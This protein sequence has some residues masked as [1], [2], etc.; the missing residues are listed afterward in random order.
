MRLAV[1]DV[2]SGATPA[3][4]LLCVTL[5]FAVTYSV[6]IGR[7]DI[8]MCGRLADPLGQHRPACRSALD[9]RAGER[10]RAGAHA[11]HP[12][13]APGRR[14]A[15]GLRRCAAGTFPQ[16]ARRPRHYRRDLGRRLRRDARDSPGRR[17]L[18]AAHRRLR[19]RD[20][21]R[22]RRDVPRERQRPH[23][24]PDPGACRRDRLVVL[25]GGD[26]HHQ[27]PGRSAPEAARH[28]L[29][30]DGKHRLHQLPRPGADGGR[31]R[32]GLGRDLSAALSDQHPV[33]RRGQGARA[34]LSDRSSSAG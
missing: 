27:A 14:G 31:H 12:G 34:R 29:L 33:A 22:P 18:S 30:A 20:R 5:V 24:D 9:R 15:R 16:P 3:I 32:P 23:L 1:G 26:L 25:R 4:A 11:A 13:G 19:L 17:R 28:H 6:T 10:R 21:Q 7:Y 8:G 2:R